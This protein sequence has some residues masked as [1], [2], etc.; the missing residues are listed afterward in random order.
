MLIAMLL[1]FSGCSIT[2]QAKQASALANCDFRIQTVD[3]ISLA[4]IDFQNVHSITD[5][6]LTDLGKI[7]AG[8]AA[9][10]FPLSFRMNLEG[11]NPNTRE[12]GLQKIEWIL[13]IDDVQMTS[14]FLDHPFLIPPKGS[15][16]IPVEMAFD[17]KKVFSGKSA[18]TIIKYCL[19]LAAGSNTPIRFKIKLKPTILVGTAA[20]KYP[21]YITINTVYTAK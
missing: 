12:A 17:L 16:V 11:R 10:V 6:G 18:E 9:P 13:Y 5:L 19:N 8:F 1:V 2:R 20:L 7:L 21:G 3:N 4:G 14:G 15:A